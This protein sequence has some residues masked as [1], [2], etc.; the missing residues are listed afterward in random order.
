MSSGL[1]ADALIALVKSG[2]GD[3]ALPPA[4]RTGKGRVARMV[5]VVINIDFIIWIGV[6]KFD[7]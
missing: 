7:T 3:L 1:S 2:F 5:A 4:G 6:T